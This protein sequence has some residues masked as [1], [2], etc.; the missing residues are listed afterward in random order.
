MR[1][2]SWRPRF[3]LNLKI[4]QASCLPNER[5]ST[6]IAAAT[7]PPQAGKMPALPQRLVQGFKVHT[8]D[9]AKLNPNHALIAL[10]AR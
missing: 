6:S 1:V 9:A 5:V 3:P 4:G 2:Q 10:S 8:A 7:P